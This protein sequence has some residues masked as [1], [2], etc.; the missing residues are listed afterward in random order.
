MNKNY[1][2]YFFNVPLYT[3]YFQYVMYQK[4]N[5]FKLKPLYKKKYE[6]ATNHDNLKIIDDFYWIINLILWLPFK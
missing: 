3:P 2:V 6:R 4:K 5:H 1:L